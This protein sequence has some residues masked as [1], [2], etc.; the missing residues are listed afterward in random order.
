MSTRALTAHGGVSQVF[1]DLHEAAG[2][3]PASSV[4]W[5]AAAYEQHM[6]PLVA[7]GQRHQVDGDGEGWEGAGVV[8]AHADHDS[9]L[10]PT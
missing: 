3:G 5:N 8:V 4:R 1:V 7:D 6:Q 2:E 9:P 10:S